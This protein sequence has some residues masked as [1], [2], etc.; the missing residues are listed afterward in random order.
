VSVHEASLIQA[1]IDRVEV[2]AR[3][4][5]AVAVSRVRV[6]LGEA[7]GVERELFELAYATFRERTVCAA[8][9]L[10]VVPVAVRWAC[11]GCGREPEPGAPLACVAC[12]RPLRLVA[13]DEILLERIELEVA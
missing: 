11:P 6:A 10:E 12:G 3:A 8:A 9:E 5:G 1:L 7:A 4:R 13:G 2:E